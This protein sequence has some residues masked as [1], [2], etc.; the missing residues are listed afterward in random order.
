MPSAFLV[1]DTATAPPTAL[2]FHG[3]QEEANARATAMRDDGQ[4]TVRAH[5]GSVTVGS[6][7]NGLRNGNWRYDNGVFR[8]VVLADHPDAGQGRVLKR[9]VAQIADL[10]S[11]ALH[12]SWQHFDSSR[13]GTTQA[14]LASWTGFC[15]ASC[16]AL[17]DGAPGAL[18]AATVRA[19]VQALRAEIPDAERVAWFFWGHA[20]A[21]WQA[22]LFADPRHILV[23]LPDGTAA[24]W[25]H[26]GVAPTLTPTQWSHTITTHY[27][28]ATAAG[29]AAA[30]PPSGDTPSAPSNLAAAPRDGGG[31]ITWSAPT[32]VGD[33]P[34]IGYLVRWRE[35]GS[36][37]EWEELRVTTRTA[38]L[39]GLENGTSYDVTVAAT[40]R[41]GNGEQAT[42]TLTPA[43]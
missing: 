23:A 40:S 19:L 6:H 13:Y 25:A 16:R 32:D 41:R 33:S 30:A 42:V 8:Q 12:G 5:S 27:Q 24:P 22:A 20:T 11:R 7:V 3:S 14:W 4:S 15:W 17:E 10:A 39:T 43:L 35:Q 37:D 29:A 38:T 34:I 26:N 2:S 36:S 9:Q 18:R 21:S 31:V 1:M 28:A